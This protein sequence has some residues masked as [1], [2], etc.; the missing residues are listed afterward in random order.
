MKG[1]HDRDGQPIALRFNAARNTERNMDELLGIAR[2]IIADK[3]VNKAEAE[4]LIRWIKRNVDYLDEWPTSM[5]YTRV[6]E[7]L[8]DGLLDKE[9]QKELLDLLR[10]YTG[11]ELIVDTHERASSTLPLDRPT[12][13]IVIPQKLFCLTGKFTSGSR[14]ECIDAIVAAGGLFKPYVTKG[15]DY[16]VLGALCSRDWAHT[17]YGRKI[18]KAMDY[19]EKG[20]PIAIV[21]EYDWTVAVYSK[22][23]EEWPTDQLN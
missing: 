8:Q 16:V 11:N 20:H 21:S 14:Q 4:F 13:K 15:T 7:M 3:K 6:A 10:S 2:G 18:E 12:P 22:V 5:L 23:N 17:S 19:K 1:V 9:E